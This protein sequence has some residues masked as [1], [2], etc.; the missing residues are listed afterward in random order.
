MTLPL[1]I[2]YPISHYYALLKQK[3]EPF[4]SKDLSFCMI[5]AKERGKR[6][7]IYLPSKHAQDYLSYCEE[8]GC[9]WEGL[10]NSIPEKWKQRR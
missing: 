4:M 5:T 2:Q 6:K 9:E 7:L 1:F 3:E 8:I 10:L